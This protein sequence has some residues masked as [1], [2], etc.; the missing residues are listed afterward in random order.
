MK[1]CFCRVLL[2]V[3]IAL[4]ALIW[5]PAGWARMAIVIAAALLAVA[6]FFP[7]ACCCCMKREKPVEVEKP[8]SSA[9]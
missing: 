7:A 9:V 5:W 6:G 1:N 8:S 3:A 2:A 4:I